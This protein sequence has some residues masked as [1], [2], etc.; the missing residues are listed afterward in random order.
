M[1]ARRELHPEE[2]ILH[3]G[4]VR[5]HTIHEDLPARI[6]RDARHHDATLRR[7]DRTGKLRIL[8]ARELQ[9]L[10]LQH[11]LQRAQRV[12]IETIYIRRHALP[13][14]LTVQG[15]GIACLEIAELQKIP[16]IDV[17][18]ALLGVTVIR[19]YLLHGCVVHV[20]IVL[21]CLIRRK[22]VIRIIKLAQHTGH[23]RCTVEGLAQAVLRQ[24]RRA[25]MGI[26]R[27]QRRI[28]QHIAERQCEL[29]LIDTGHAG[30]RDEA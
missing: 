4:D 7:R 14:R 29:R 17:I 15:H 28:R 22:T 12:V 3:L 18:E 30:A 6:I 26:P 16:A 20:S 19:D 24:G 25:G 21:P 2:G 8:P 9:A 23:H 11:I 5:L 1:R 13:I 27:L 10:V